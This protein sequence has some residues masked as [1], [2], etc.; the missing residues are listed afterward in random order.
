[1]K[2]KTVMNSKLIKFIT[3][4]VV[5]AAI[6][7]GS[8]SASRTVS[9]KTLHIYATIPSRTTVEVSDNGQVFFTS[10]NSAAATDV[11][12]SEGNTTVLSVVAR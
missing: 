10:N 5:I 11:I 6:A 12:Q 1:M 2:E 9:S 3:A 8:I 4:V 7:V